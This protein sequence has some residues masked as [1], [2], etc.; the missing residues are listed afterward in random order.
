V[1]DLDGFLYTIVRDQHDINPRLTLNV[2]DDDF[3]R[4]GFCAQLIVK[5]EKLSQLIVDRTNG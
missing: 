3:F 4:K 5:K 2:D 1:K